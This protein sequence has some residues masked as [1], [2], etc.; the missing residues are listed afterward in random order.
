VVTGPT[1][2]VG[3]S[4]TPVVDV[5]DGTDDVVAAPSDP[6]HAA[7]ASATRTRARR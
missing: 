6:A 7:L 4:E 1:V 3:G 2:V 5:D